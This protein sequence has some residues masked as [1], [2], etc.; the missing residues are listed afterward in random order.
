M[1]DFSPARLEAPQRQG[2]LYLASVSP[3]QGLEQ[4]IA[5]CWVG[6]VSSLASFPI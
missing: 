6:I 4:V 2:L 5:L 3:P 1:D